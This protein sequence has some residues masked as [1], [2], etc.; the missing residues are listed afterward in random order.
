MQTNAAIIIPAVFL[1]YSQF[2]YG[3]FDGNS[4]QC[5]DHAMG[6]I[7]VLSVFNAQ[8]YRGTSIHAGMGQWFGFTPTQIFNT[9]YSDFCDQ[10]RS[11][12]QIF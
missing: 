10:L 6:L 1:R 9:E 7:C 11:G 5:T 3:Q 4:E 8:W 12:Y 2:T